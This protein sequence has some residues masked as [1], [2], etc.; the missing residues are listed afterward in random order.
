MYF[1]YLRGKQYELLS[2]K[3]CATTIGASR[4]IIPIIEP[5]KRNTSAL[6]RTIN[7]YISELTPF[8]LVVN[9]QVGELKGNHSYLGKE[10][11]LEKVL[12]GG[13]GIAGFVIAQNTSARDVE[14]FLNHFE[15]SRVAFIHSYSLPAPQQLLDLILTRRNIAYQIFI[16]GVTGSSYQNLFRSYQRVLVR[17]GFR[18]VKNADYP[19]DEFFSELH[20]TYTGGGFSGFGDFT[21]VG[22]EHAETGGPA[23]AVTIHL[24]YLRPDNDV[25]IRHFVSDRT[26][27]TKDKAGK[28]MEALEKLIRFL[29][30]K[31]SVGC[32]WCVFFL[33]LYLC[34]FF[35]EVGPKKGVLKKSQFNFGVYW[36]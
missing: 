19:S 8:V 34:L 26:T 18:K 32:G 2:L 28:F 13:S 23:H 33:V 4:K 22:R 10:L 7:H 9:P 20:H 1:P 35:F 5:V 3:D 12:S 6:L 15:S 27:T 16:D 29:K 17:D 24:T 30:K 11:A 25:W 14:N 36:F 21:I 31:K